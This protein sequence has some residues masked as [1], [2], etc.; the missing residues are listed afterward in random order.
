MRSV[1]SVRALFRAAPIA[2]RNTE[3]G[4][5]E[6]VLVAKPDARPRQQRGG[7]LEPQRLVLEEPRQ[8]FS[9]GGVPRAQTQVL[10]DA[11]LMLGDRLLPA[12]VDVDRLGVRPPVCRAANLR[13][14]P[15][16]SRGAC[17]GN[18]PST[19]TKATWYAKPNRLWGP[20]R[21]AIS[22]RS[23]SSME[24]DAFHVPITVRYNSRRCIPWT[25]REKTVAY[26]RVSTAQQDVRSQRLAILEYARKHDLRIDDFI[27][28]TASGQASEKRRRLD[29]LLNGLQ[30]GDRLIV[31][32][33]SR[34]GRSLGQI[35]AILDALAKA[36]VAFVALKE[37]IRVEG[38]RDIQT[39]VMTTL[40]ALFAEV[41][42][43]LISE[44]TR[45]GLAKARASGRKLGR[46]KGSLGVSRLDGKG[47]RDP[48]LPRAAR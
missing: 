6:N 22:R 19:R 43:D 27:E 3:I 1:S 38:K 40:F 48:A 25:G 4:R 11:L 15:S 20:R 23:A 13:I 2:R 46:P 29:E 9:G 17:C 35:V 41:E 31:S 39:K 12:G 45:E 24:H 42:R 14:S 16:I 32:E 5:R 26:L 8:P 7:P 10:T 34:L 18:L 28:A 47:G 33:L 36:G 30:R 44:R 21:R 37:D